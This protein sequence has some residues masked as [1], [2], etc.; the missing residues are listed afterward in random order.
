MFPDL[1]MIDLITVYRAYASTRRSASTRVLVFLLSLTLAAFAIVKA[2]HRHDL[3]VDARGCAVCAAIMDELPTVDR[4]PPIAASAPTPAYILLPA[5]VYVSWHGFP[6]P[7]PPSCGPPYVPLRP[8][9][10]VF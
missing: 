7:L 6:L 1:G 5:T 4:L 9:V 2:G 10:A 3:D 8:E